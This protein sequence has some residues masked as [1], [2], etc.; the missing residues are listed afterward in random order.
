MR[1]VT[2]LPPTTQNRVVEHRVGYTVISVK[3]LRLYSSVTSGLDLLVCG[4]ES[5]VGPGILESVDWRP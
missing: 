4:K 1:S 5:S 3:C 2:P